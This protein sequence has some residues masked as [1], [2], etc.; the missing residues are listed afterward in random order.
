MHSGKPP[1]PPGLGAS[2]KVIPAGSAGLWVWREISQPCLAHRALLSHQPGLGKHCPAFH[3]HPSRD[4][5]D[6]RSC[7]PPRGRT[8]GVCES[9]PWITPMCPHSLQ[10]PDTSLCCRL[11]CRAQFPSQQHPVL[12]T[13][14]ARGSQSPLWTERGLRG[15][16][17]LQC[18]H[19]HQRRQKMLMKPLLLWL[20]CCLCQIMSNY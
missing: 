18:F 7:F 15:A 17:A 14:L 16:S 12:G 5:Q 2:A 9:S 19:L 6:C 1:Q 11:G 4:K 10:T 3:A 13:A 8:T 20:L